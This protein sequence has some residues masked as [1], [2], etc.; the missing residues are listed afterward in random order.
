LGA[1]GLESLSELK[2]NHIQQRVQGTTVKSY[3]ELYPCI[4]ENCL[5]SDSTMPA[6]WKADWQFA[7]ADRW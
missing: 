2:P 6:D 7:Q 5:L 4:E 3:A 1:A